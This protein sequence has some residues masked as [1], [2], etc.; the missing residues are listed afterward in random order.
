MKPRWRKTEDYPLAAR[1]DRY[2]HTIV[3]SERRSFGLPEHCPLPNDQKKPVAS[4]RLRK[5]RCYRPTNWK[6][7]TPVGLGKHFAK[8]LE[9]LR[10]PLLDQFIDLAVGLLSFPPIRGHVPT[11][12]QTPWSQYRA[13]VH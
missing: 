2:L 10:H 4:F 8:L 6:L 9:I 1:F 3:C 7:T 13:A 11:H 12:C 5:T